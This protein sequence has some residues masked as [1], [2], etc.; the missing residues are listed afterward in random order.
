MEGVDLMAGISQ[1][2]GNECPNSFNVI[3]SGDLEMEWP[4]LNLSDYL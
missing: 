3:S 2:L 1:T 4:E